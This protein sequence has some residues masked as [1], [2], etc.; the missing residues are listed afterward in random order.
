MTVYLLYTGNA[1]LN[2][3]SLELL[4]VCSSPERACELARQHSNDGTEP[5]SDEDFDELI[6]QLQTYGRDENYLICETE[7]DELE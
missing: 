6:V 7:V 3:S 5:I 4:S 2:T 1:W